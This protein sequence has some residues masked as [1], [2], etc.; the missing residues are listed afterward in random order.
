MIVLHQGFLYC[1][2]IIS[3]ISNVSTI[4]LSLSSLASLNIKDAFY[5]ASICSTHSLI[6]S[7]TMKTIAVLFLACATVVLALVCTF[8]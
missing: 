5:I 3:I 1:L 6:H 2:V 8:S 7:V 4:P